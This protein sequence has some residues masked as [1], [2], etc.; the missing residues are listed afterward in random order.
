MRYPLLFL[1]AILL[2]LTQ[3]ASAAD[4]T[5]EITS[6]IVKAR[7]YTASY[8]VLA[9]QNLK[10]NDLIQAEKLYATA[11][12]NYSAW[13]A[14]VTA[15]LRNGT[16]GKNLN[17][18]TN[19]QKEASDASGAATTFVAFVDSK[20]GQQSKAIL[21]TL[22]SLADLGMKLWNGIKDRIDKDRTAAADAFA[23]D[24]KWSSWNDIKVVADTK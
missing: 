14:Y 3:L 2:G 23:K 4:P 9:K 20:T 24:T 16:K 15:S 13:N 6:E 22:S 10:G 1:G 18:D 11:Y 5:A 17:K 19:Y 7:E 21:P 8:V 12:A